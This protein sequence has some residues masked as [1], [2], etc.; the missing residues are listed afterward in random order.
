MQ[1]RCMNVW[2]F[3]ILF[4]IAYAKDLTFHIPFTWNDAVFTVAANAVNGCVFCLHTGVICA[5]RMCAG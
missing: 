3:R 1:L 2:H 5:V 4:V